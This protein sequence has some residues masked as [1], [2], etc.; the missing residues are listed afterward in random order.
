MPQ[1]L[2]ILPDEAEVAIA[3]L[4]EYLDAIPWQSNL[5]ILLN[6]KKSNKAPVIFG[7]T[8]YRARFYLYRFPHFA[9]RSLLIDLRQVNFYLIF[10]ISKVLNAHEQLSIS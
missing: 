10:D 5:K 8:I 2:R 3:D 4:T 9:C 7:Y 6:I 1:P